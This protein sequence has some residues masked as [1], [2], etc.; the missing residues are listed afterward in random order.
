MLVSYTWLFRDG[1]DF[2][3][4]PA[5]GHLGTRHAADW[6]RLEISASLCWLR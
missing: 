6:S 3:F 1:N 4:S 2:E 5:I